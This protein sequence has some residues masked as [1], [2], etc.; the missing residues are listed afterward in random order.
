MRDVDLC[1]LDILK[2]RCRPGVS[3]GPLAVARKLTFN[4]CTNHHTLLQ[5]SSCSCLSLWA[6][7][8]STTVRFII[9]VCY[10]DIDLRLA[11]EQRRT[12]GTFASWT[13]VESSDTGHERRHECTR[14]VSGWSAS[15]LSRASSLQHDVSY[16]CLKPFSVIIP[17][18]RRIH[19]ACTIPLPIVGSLVATGW[20][21]NYLRVAQSEQ[22][23]PQPR[24]FSR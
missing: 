24:S 19:L 22:M 6:Y 8:A 12:G 15:R 18:P 16:P 23:L 3:V 11:S 10:L 1:R 4:W 14:Q 17:L 9:P 20:S 21:Q 2:Q 13:L 7:S 5:Q